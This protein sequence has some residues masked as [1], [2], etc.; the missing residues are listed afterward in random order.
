MTRRAIAAPTPARRFAPEPSL[1]MPA[2]RARAERDAALN[3][4][5]LGSAL[6]IDWSLERLL[7]RLEGRC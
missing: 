1:A 6:S 7:D 4:S 2:P 5:E 3:A